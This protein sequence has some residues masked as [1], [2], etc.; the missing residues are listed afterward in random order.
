[1]PE[2]FICHLQGYGSFWLWL[3]IDLLGILLLEATFINNT[4]P[5]ETAGHKLCQHTFK[6]KMQNFDINY[7]KYMCCASRKKKSYN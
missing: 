6:S 7:L 1:M 4:F 5:N 3:L 2:A